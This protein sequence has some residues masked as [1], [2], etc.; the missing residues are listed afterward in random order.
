ML[1]IF[2]DI[3]KLMRDGQAAALATVISVNGSAP[4]EIGAKMLVR[5]DGTT[6]GSIGGGNIEF[7]VCERAL[8]VI[9][10][11]KPKLLHFD[12]TGTDADKDKMICGGVMDVFVEPILSP[13]TLYIFGGGHISLALVKIGRIIGFRIVVID[14]KPE[15]ANR[16]RFPEAND[17]LFGDFTEA[18]SQLKLDKSSYVVIVTRSHLSD[19][20][21][22][23]WAVNTEA[24]YIG[25]I[26]SKKKVNTIFANL[27]SKGVCEELLKNVHAPIGLDIDAETP[28]E[29]A[30]SIL[31]EIIKVRRT[32]Q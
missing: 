5:N 7:E 23:E 29:I 11:G 24:A 8:E 27:R 14:E 10:T 18:F 19:K 21:I 16:D 9:S 28:E 20:L 15:F 1:N 6:D 12:L 26:G 25:M 13:P 4:R 32:V 30:V 3:V 31:A 2:E 17:I 22:L